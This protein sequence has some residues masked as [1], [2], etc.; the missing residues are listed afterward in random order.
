MSNLHCPRHEDGTDQTSK[1]FAV[2]GAGDDEV[3]EM[4][5]TATAD[6]RQVMF[7]INTGFEAVVVAIGKGSERKSGD[8]SGSSG[9][10]TPVSR[11]SG[12]EGDMRSDRNEPL[13][14]LKAGIY[15]ALYRKGHE[16]DPGSSPELYHC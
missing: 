5:G 12:D 13:C 11:E 10:H 6:L 15:M 1:W 7:R 3:G 16:E 9:G 8:M 4:L 2:V 14:K